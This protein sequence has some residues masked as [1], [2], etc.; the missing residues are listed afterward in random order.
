[1]DVMRRWL[2]RHPR[3]SEPKRYVWK[4]D[5]TRWWKPWLSLM[6]KSI[7]GIAGPS[8]PH[9]FYFE[10]RNGAQ[11]INILPL[12]FEGLSKPVHND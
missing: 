8:A 10:R 7:V 2:V 11:R 1:M 12:V 5:Q 6:G 4:L 9:V 3:P